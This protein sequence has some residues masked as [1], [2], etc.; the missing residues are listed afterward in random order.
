VLDARQVP[1]TAPHPVSTLLRAAARYVRQFL[2]SERSLTA[3]APDELL[4]VLRSVVMLLVMPAETVSRQAVLQHVKAFDGDGS[5]A[6]ELEPRPPGRLA[7]AA[8]RA[9]AA[10][11]GAAAPVTSLATVAAIATVLA[12]FALHRL[13]I[14]DVLHFMP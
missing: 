11:A 14:I 7:V 6:V 8:S 4:E 12:L 1:G 3:S 10:I 2:I 9:A 5:P 13:D